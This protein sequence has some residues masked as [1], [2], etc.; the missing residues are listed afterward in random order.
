MTNWSY[1]SSLKMEAIFIQNIRLPLSYMALQPSTLKS[2]S[3]LQVSK[4]KVA[5]KIFEPKY[6]ANNSGYYII[7]NL[8]ISTGHPIL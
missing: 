1:S 5:S 4:N 2:N 8:T 7:G 6:I 3:K